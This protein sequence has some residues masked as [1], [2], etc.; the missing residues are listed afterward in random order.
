MAV[1]H[2]DPYRIPPFYDTHLHHHAAVSCCL[3][4]LCVCLQH[5]LSLSACPCPV[6]FPL[7]FCLTKGTAFL[8]P[9]VLVVS[10][11]VVSV[12]S[13]TKQVANRIPE[14][15]DVPN[16]HT[17]GLSPTFF[18]PVSP[19]SRRSAG[20]G[21]PNWA[22]GLLISGTAVLYTHVHYTHTP[23]TPPKGFLPGLF[24]STTFRP[25]TKPTL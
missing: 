4:A 20:H 9:L 12:G 16:K 11:P 10:R 25:A 22:V 19:S 5:T 24:L 6:F 23:P 21:D 8:F 15:Q 1:V 13:C 18:W 2:P 17:A 14:F 7:L 3:G